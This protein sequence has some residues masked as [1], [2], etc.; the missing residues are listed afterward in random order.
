[1][2]SRRVSIALTV[3][4]LSATGCEE[5]RPVTL[6]VA[7]DLPTA[8]RDELEE[9]SFRRYPTLSDL[10]RL[11]ALAALENFGYRQLS[12]WWRLRGTISA[13]RGAQGWGE[14]SRKGFATRESGATA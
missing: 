4:A 2:S 9:L 14:M 8:L 3:V 10:L 6:T 12:A 1:M 7:T 13:L 11:F 5:A